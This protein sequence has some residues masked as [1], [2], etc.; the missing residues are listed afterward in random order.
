MVHVD[1][2]LYHMKSCTT[3]INQGG[4]SFQKYIRSAGLKCDSLAVHVG[5]KNFTVLTL[6]I[7]LDSRKT[8]K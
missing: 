4:E 8:R 5:N 6:Q 2:N 7:A 3:K 1:R